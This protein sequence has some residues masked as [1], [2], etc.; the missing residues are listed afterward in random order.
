MPLYEYCCPHCN[1]RFELLRPLSE[2]KETAFCP[3][4]HNSAQRMLSCFASFSKS[5][6]GVSTPIGGSSS[7]STCAATSCDTCHG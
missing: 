7:C 3:R 4:C 6:E 1:L 5:A 2:S